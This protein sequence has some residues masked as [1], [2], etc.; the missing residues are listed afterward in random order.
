MRPAKELKGF[1]KVFLKAGE[2]KTVEIAVPVKDLAF[3]DDKAHE[4][5]V[6]ADKFTLHCAASSADVKTSVTVEVK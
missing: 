2:S 6:E 5:T 4:W 3:F 1:R